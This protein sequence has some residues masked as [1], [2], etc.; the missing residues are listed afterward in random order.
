M[1]RPTFFSTLGL[2]FAITPLLACNF[3]YNLPDPNDPPPFA[4]TEAQ[5]VPPSVST[6]LIGPGFQGVIFTADQAEE[7]GLDS[8]VGSGLPF[9][10]YW[11][12]TEADVLA[13]EDGVE[14]YLDS[15]GEQFYD[16]QPP[17]EEWLPE[18]GRQYVGIVENGRQIIYANYFC[19]TDSFSYWQEDLVLVLDGG[20]CYFQ[21]YYDVA[22]NEHYGLMVNGMA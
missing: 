21:L 9:D 5:I 7:M 18:F 8:W 13:L 4:T 14:A 3:L 15:R 19:D 1:R 6:L 16:R 20:D 17:V 12:P 22:A 2:I 10:G 11:T